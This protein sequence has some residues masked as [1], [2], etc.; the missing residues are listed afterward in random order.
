RR[1]RTTAATP[2]AP[3]PSGVRTLPAA[4]TAL[5]AVRPR[6]GNRT[7]VPAG[8]RVT[9]RAKKL[10]YMA[11]LTVPRAPPP[12][13]HPAS[14]APARASAASRRPCRV[15]WMAPPPGIGGTPV[16]S[17]P[18]VASRQ[19]PPGAPVCCRRDEAGQ[20]LDPAG[21]GG[22]AARRRG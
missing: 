4:A 7:L 14:T 18:G 16:S 21:R 17:R 6:L 5:W 19:H 13:E 10:S 12:P 15:P 2:P 1:S 22:G 8:T 3:P 11:T 20:D 9:S